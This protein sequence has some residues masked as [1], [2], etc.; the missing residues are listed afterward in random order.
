MKKSKKGG[1]FE[2]FA[3]ALFAPLFRL[4]L[5][6]K[7][8][9]GEHIPRE[10]GAIVAVNHISFL[11]AIAVAAAL[12]R[13]PRYLAKAELFRIP[14]LS[15]VIRAF[16]ATP[17]DRGKSDVGAIRRA[18]AI[19]EGGE[20]LTLFPQ[21]TL[22]KG[23]NPAD[24]PIKSGVAMIAARAGVPIIP[25]CIKLKNNRYAFLRRT[26]IIVGEPLSLK[27]LGLTTDDADYRAAA[28]E[29]FRSLCALG[30]YLPTR[31][32]AEA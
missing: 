31:E 5:R 28:K 21:G 24:T 19:A 17:L 7:L 20:L 10:G 26:E 23:K 16:G 27:D 6:V 8:R 14:L 4:I 9:G 25:V 32:E 18:I 13:H 2:R 12:P 1:R 11:D 29:A 22:Q 3:Y 15:S 30:G